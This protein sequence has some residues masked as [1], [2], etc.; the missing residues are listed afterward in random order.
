MFFP[1]NMWQ[2]FTPAKRKAP[3]RQVRR[4]L[5]TAS[6]SFTPPQPLL[7][8]NET[9]TNSKRNHCSLATFSST[10]ETVISAQVIRC[11]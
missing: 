4:K 11:T 2:H 3:F 1:K 8:H 10:Y 7:R 9:C 6:P 5:F